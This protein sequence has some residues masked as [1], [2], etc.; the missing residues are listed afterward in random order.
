M[1]DENFKIEIEALTAYRMF[2]FIV[3]II[4]LLNGFEQSYL[5]EYK[6]SNVIPWGILIGSIPD[7]YLLTGKFIAWFR[8]EWSERFS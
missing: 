1:S 8:S 6:L 3:A 4:F 2:F 7:L 5:V